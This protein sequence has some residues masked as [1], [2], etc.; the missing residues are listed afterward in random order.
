MHNSKN[1][2][3]SFT[4]RFQG[5]TSHMNKDGIVGIISKSSIP[6]DKTHINSLTYSPGS[7]KK[8]YFN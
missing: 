8:S 7:Y 1:M 3:C 5:K 2:E 4:Q 6:I